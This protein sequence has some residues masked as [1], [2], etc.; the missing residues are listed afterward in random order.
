M[1]IKS[2]EQVGTVQSI[3]R[4]AVKSMNGVKLDKAEFTEGGILGDR[5]YA[6]IDQS[7]QKSQV[8]NFLKNG[9]S[10]LN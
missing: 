5:C 8:Q 7:N 2:K 3:W 6:L 10:C 9:L 4:Y 1:D